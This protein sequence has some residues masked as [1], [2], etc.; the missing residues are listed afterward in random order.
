MI[1]ALVAGAAIVPSLLLLWFFYARDDYPEP[2]RVVWTTFALGIVA[3]VPIAMIAWPL[4][5]W[6][7]SFDNPFV[8]GLA[9]AFLGAAIPEE[10]CKLWVLRGYAMRHDAFD[11]PRDGVVYGVAASLGFATFENLVYVAQ[12]GGSVAILR[13]LTAVPSHAF[14]GAIMGQYLGR[15][16]FAADPGTR[17][18]LHNA[19]LAVPILLHGLYNFPLLAGARI[20]ETD[21]AQIVPAGLL[22]LIAPAVLAIEGLWAARLAR[23]G[24]SAPPPAPTV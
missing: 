23:R 6:A 9:S 16:R 5:H 4:D 12:E 11:E 13:A 15:A 19:A 17:R 20:D 24:R 7:K 8:Y 2:P 1:P 3:V 21:P 14:L 18:R 22:L 10:L